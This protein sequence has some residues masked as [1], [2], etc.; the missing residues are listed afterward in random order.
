MRIYMT[1]C[2]GGDGSASIE[3]Y[4][5]QECI[6]WLESDENED[7]DYYQMG[8]GGTW[9]EVPDGTEVGFPSSYHRIKTLAELKGEEE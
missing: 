6:D 2:D 8:E 3:F 5:S 9:I 4:E 7:S 1:T